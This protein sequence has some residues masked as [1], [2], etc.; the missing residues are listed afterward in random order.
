MYKTV[1]GSKILDK[2]VSDPE[3]ISVTNTYSLLNTDVTVKKTVVDESVIPLSGQTFSFTATLDSG[4]LFGDTQPDGVTLNGDKTQASF[5]LADEG[6]VALNVPIG[7]VLTVV[8]ADNANYAVKWQIGSGTETESATATYT[9]PEENAED[10]I[11]TYTRRTAHLTVSKTVSG[12]MG[13]LDKPFT[14]TVTAQGATGAISA[15]K[16]NAA[17][18]EET[19]T[20]T[21]SDGVYTFTLTHGESMKLPGLPVNASVTAAEAAASPYTTYYKVDSAAEAEGASATLTIAEAGNTVAFR[22]NNSQSVDTGVLLDNTPYLV[23]MS[24]AGLWLIALL[25]RKRRW[26]A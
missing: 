12:N 17:G 10:I 2:F 5:T 23:I 14:F 1:N 3:V 25:L 15:V 20:L 16:T 6:S 24:V 22:N 11:F 7:A 13:E 21:P 4:K 19:V 18:T 9:V 26:R 8:E